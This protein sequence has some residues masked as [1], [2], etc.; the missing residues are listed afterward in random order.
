MSIRVLIVDDNP[1]VRLSLA[2]GFAAQGD[3]DLVGEAADGE[4]AVTLVQS[5]PADVIVM[6]EH[7]PQL[8]GLGAVARLRSLGIETPV[9]I[10]TAD[11]RVAGLIGDLHGVAVLLKGE[12]GLA[13]TVTAVRS[14]ARAS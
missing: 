7:M 10:L 3:I 12:A 11:P 2:R 6:D 4:R 14:A 1:A 13:E 8:S 9:L 5:V